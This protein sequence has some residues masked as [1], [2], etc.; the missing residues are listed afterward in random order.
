MSALPLARQA[1]QPKLHDVMFAGLMSF[2]LQGAASVFYGP[3]L[4]YIAAETGQPVE[5]LGILF[6]LQ[7]L[8]FFASTLVANRAARRFEIRRGAALSSALMGVGALGLAVLPF[9][10]NLASALLIGFGGGVMEI[11]LNRLVE[12]LSGDA[13]AASLTRLHATFGVGAVAMPLIVAAIA[14]LG[15][16]WRIGGLVLYGIALVNSLAILRWNEFSVP[17]GDEVRWRT[18]PWRSIAVFVVMVIVYT[19]VETAVGAWATTFFAKLGQGAI[20]GAVA[21]SLFFL[22]FTVGRI[23]LAETTDRL[24]FARAVRVGTGLGAAALLF[25]FFENFALLGFALAGIAFS[26]VFPTLLAWGPR[27]HPEIRAQMASLSIAAAGVGGIVL[28]YLI[29]QGVG[30]FGAGAL[31]PL[32]IGTALFVFGLTFLE[33]TRPA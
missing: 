6:V 3:A 32:L 21:T 18:L 15:W 20:L 5:R 23:T 19:G 26:I 25:T 12:L 27:H 31:T 17:H 33:T 4:V 9:P 30:S 14:L 13:P 22:T 8:G 10:I 29:G 11:L 24:G 28:P 1:F 2:F 16:N 7:S